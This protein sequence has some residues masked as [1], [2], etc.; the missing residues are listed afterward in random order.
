M[1]DFKWRHFRGEMMILWAVR[2]YCKYGISY[3][4]LEE[5]KTAYATIKGF[6]V[7]RALKQG[8]ARPWRYQE[9]IVGEVRLIERNFGL[10]AI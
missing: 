10:A 7:M 3:R 5:M 8:Q 1:G 2:W 4:E 6:E 9:G